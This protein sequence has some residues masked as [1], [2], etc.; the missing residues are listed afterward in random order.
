MKKKLQNH[1]YEHM[2]LMVCMFAQLLYIVDFSFR[3]MK[4]QE[5]VF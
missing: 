2:D 4:K 5:G 1:L 3:F